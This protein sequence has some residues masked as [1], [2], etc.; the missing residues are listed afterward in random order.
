M[1]EYTIL[2]AVH[3]KN[4]PPKEGLRPSQVVVLTLGDGANTHEAEWITLTTTDVSTLNPKTVNGEVSEFQHISGTLKP[5]Q[6]GL[7]FEKDKPNAPGGRPRDPKDTAA[8]S[9]A[10]AQD[11]A[12]AYMQVKATMG[13]LKDD[14]KP[15]ALLPL[16]DWFQNDVKRYQDRDEPKTVHGLPVHNEPEKTGAPDVP[17][18][19]YEPPAQPDGTEPFAA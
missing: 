14:F 8:M 16:M 6:Y 1:P 4:L 3:K 2:S 10:H 9:R 12:L 19:P 17:V 18:E 13:V 11:M 15:D 7:R 5:S